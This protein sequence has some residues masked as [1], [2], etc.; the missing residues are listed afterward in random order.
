MRLRHDNREKDG[1]PRLN[2]AEEIQSNSSKKRSGFAKFFMETIPVAVKKSAVVIAFAFATTL[3]AYACTGKFDTSGNADSTT[4]APVDSVD[5]DT[6]VDVPGSCPGAYDELEGEVSPLMRKTESRLLHF[7]GPEDESVSGTA[8]ITL[9]GDIEGPLVLGD[10]PGEADTVAAF[11]GSEATVTPSFRIDIP[12]AHAEMPAIG[13]ESCSPGA[14]APPVSMF[15][16]EANLTLIPA[17]FGPASGGV[18]AGLV[19]PLAMKVI[20]GVGAELPSPIPLGAE[21]TSVMVVSEPS[22]LTLAAKPLSSD[23]LELSTSEVNASVSS[24]SSKKLKIFK[25]DTMLPNI[26]RWRAEGTPG[27]DSSTYI[28]LRPCMSEGADA[29]VENSAELLGFDVSGAVSDTCGKVFAG[30][31]VVSITAEFDPT[32]SPPFGI[33]PAHLAGDYSLVVEHNYGEGLD[34]L[35]EESPKAYIFLERRSTTFLD[36]GEL[37]VMDINVTLT[38]QSRESNPNTGEKDTTEY[39][40]GIRLSVPAKPDNPSICGCTPALPG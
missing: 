7:N 35:S 19:N 30:F 12:D 13:S 11:G 31:D 27:P 5:G 9:G 6:D 18:E 26:G 40:F 4:D 15:N 24:A 23:G 21:V 10:C 22:T 32:R 29:I 38:L 36:S 3:T 17:Q 28:C 37:V 2:A 8:E 16:D 34:A 20:D 39:S 25:S 33:E 14:D 1:K